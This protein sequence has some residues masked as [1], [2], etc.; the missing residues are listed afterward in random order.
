MLDDVYFCNMYL[1][2]RA[3]IKLQ[4]EVWSQVGFL[5]SERLPSLPEDELVPA[6]HKAVRQLLAIQKH[7]WA[8][9][10]TQ[11]APTDCTM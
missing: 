6:L 10:A 1:D 7:S 2:T 3:M 11:V 5:F 4:F 8:L 9:V